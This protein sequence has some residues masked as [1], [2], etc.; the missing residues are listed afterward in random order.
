MADIRSFTRSKPWNPCCWLPYK[1]TRHRHALEFGLSTRGLSSASGNAIGGVTGIF[2]AKALPRSTHR[3]GR[4]ARGRDPRAARH[5]RN[6]AMIVL[7][8]RWA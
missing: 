5:E 4:M 7:E 1:R 8:L 3:T 6:G 2:V